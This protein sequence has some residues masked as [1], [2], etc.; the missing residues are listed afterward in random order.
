MLNITGTGPAHRLLIQGHTVETPD[1]SENER[2][3]SYYKATVDVNDTYGKSL[4]KP[5]GTGAA[6]SEETEP[7]PEEKPP[8]PAPEEPS[9]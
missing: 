3:L 2:A 4:H 6:E 8:A 9:V 1:S 7:A 5:V